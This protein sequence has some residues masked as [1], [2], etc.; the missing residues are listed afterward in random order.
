MLKMRRGL[1]QNRCHLDFPQSRECD[2]EICGCCGQAQYIV[3][4]LSAVS[5]S[6]TKGGV[7]VSVMRL[8][9]V[10]MRY[11]AC[12]QWLKVRIYVEGEAEVKVNADLIGEVHHRNVVYT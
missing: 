10:R 3:S 2:E 4:I 1:L 6:Q 5:Q 8:G 12:S 7:R 11:V 9:S